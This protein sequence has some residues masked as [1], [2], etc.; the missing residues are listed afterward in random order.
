MPLHTSFIA[1]AAL[2]LNLA[3]PTV[4]LPETNNAL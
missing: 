1:I 2:P 3:P 4:A